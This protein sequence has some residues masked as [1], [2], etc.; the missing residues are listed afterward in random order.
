MAKHSE[1]ELFSQA[2]MTSNFGIWEL[3]I[4]AHT[5][6]WTDGV[7][8]IL[9]YEP[10][11]FEV[12]FEKNLSFVH[13]DDS[14]IFIEQI[15]NTTTTGK[16]FDIRLRFITK[17]GS[18][19]YI[20]AKG[21]LIKDVKGKGLKISGVFQDVSHNVALETAYQKINSDLEALIENTPDVIYSLNSEFKL[22]TFNT[23]FKNTVSELGLGEVEKGMDIF[24]LYSEEKRELY[25]AV[26]LIV[27]EGK[28]YTFEDE[29]IIN[30][31]SVCYD[32]SVN[33]ILST[34]D[35]VIGVSIF[36]KD[37]TA[38][39]Q[40]QKK[41][42][43][44]KINQDAIINSTQDLIWSINPKMRLITANSAFYKMI[45]DNTG[46]IINEGDYIMVAE[47]PKEINEKWLNYYTR[48]LNGETFS[49]NYWVETDGEPFYRLI[50]FSPLF[51]AHQV[52]LGLACYT[53][54][55]TK[56]KLNFLAL[57]RKDAE[58]EKIMNSSLDVI[59]TFNK[60][61]EFVKVNAAS[62]RVW[63]YK[64]EELVGK[65][66]NLF[67]YP[68]DIDST[69]IIFKE[70]QNGLNVINFENRTIK[71]DGTIVPIIWSGTYDDK[72]EI[73][74]CIAKD[75]SALKKK[76]EEL[77]RANDILKNAQKLTKMGNWEY[78]LN[79]NEVFCSDELYSIYEIDKS[80]RANTTPKDFLKFTHP[81]DIATLIEYRDKLI[82]TAGVS[83][84]LHRIITKKNNIKYVRQVVE[85]VYD[86]KTNTK[87]L[88]ATLRD[89][90]SNILAQNEIENS[91]KKYKYLF[92]N[93]P[94]ALF[95][96]EFETLQI[97]DCNYEALELYGYTREEFL[98][99]TIRDIRPAE[100]INLIDTAT[101]NEN[102]YG[103]I[104]KETWRHQKKNRDII[105]AEITG[106]LIDYEGKRCSIALIN[107]ITEKKK[108]DQLLIANEL[109]YRTMIESSMDAILL[110]I[111]TGEILSCNEVACQ[112]FQ[113]TK[114]E[115]IAA[116]RNGL[117]DITDPRLIT[118]LEERNR[119]GKTRGE[120]TFI[121]KNGTKFPGE[122]T[123]VLFMDVN[124]LERAS[125][126]IR[127]ITNQKDAENK[128]FES[129]LRFKYA[130]KATSDAIWDWDLTTNLI[131]YGEGFNAIFGYEVTEI[132]PDISSWSKRIHPDDYN[133]VI[134][135]I[136]LSINNDE[137]Q[138]NWIDEYRYLK[139]DGVYA[140]VQDKGLIVRNKKHKAIRMVGAM[141]DI[142]QK[143]EE[144]LRLKLL[145]SVITN[146]NDSIVITEAEPLDEP[147]PKILYVN[148]AFTRMT[149]YTAEDV[150]GKTPRILQGP[151][152]D[153]KELKK[154]SK[155]LKNREECEI[156]V[157]NYKKNGEEF[158]INLCVTPVANDKGWLTHW[159]AI[160]KDVTE[161]VLAKQ[162]LESSLEERNTILE[163]IDDGFFATDRNSIVTYWNKKA[164][165]LLEEKKEN[166]IGKNLFQMF[167]EA[168]SMVFHDHYQKAIR[169]NKTVHFEEFS[170]RKQKWFEVSAF[171]SDKGLSVYF[172]DITE[173]KKIQQQFEAVISNMP[174]ITYR[175]RVDEHYTMLFMSDGVFDITGYLANDFINNKY[176]TFASIIHDE[177]LIITYNTVETLKVH[178]VF[179]IE[180]RII[181]ADGSIKWVQDK[182]RGV[183]KSDH[184]LLYIDGVV[185]DITDKKN[186]LKELEK[187][188]QEK[189]DVLE[190]ID[191]GFF[192]T[193]RNSIVTYWNKKAELLI[194]EKRENVIGKNL[195]QM[196]ANP[197]SMAFYNHYQKAIKENK[198]VHFEEFSNRRKKW[199][200]VSAF[201]SDKG[202][203]V[204]FKDV[205][206]K[207][208]IE[209]RIKSERNLLR[210]LI[211]NFP[212]TIYVKDVAA[213]KIISNKND[214]NF[215]GF[216]QEED[217]LGKTDLEL[218][219][220]ERGKTGYNHDMEIINTGKA[221]I[222]FEEYVIKNDGNP[223]WLLTTK[224]PL[225]NNENKIIG[226]L[227]IGRD[228]TDIKEAQ[229]RIKHVHIEL[230]K[231]VEQLQISNKELE[232]F[233]YVASHDLQEPLRMITSFLTQI[234]KKYNDVLDDK[235]KQ[236]I[237][238]AVDGAK[239]M[240]QIILDLLE[241]SRI[242]R[243]DEELE[244]VNLM[245]I[246]TEIQ[247]LYKKQI[248]EIPAKINTIKLPKI[249]S[250]KPPIRQVLQN[251]IS[252]ALK[253]HTIGVPTEINI[254]FEDKGNDWQFYVKDNGIGINEEYFPKIFIIFQRLHNK[255]E[256]AGT[257]IGLAIC[258]KIVDSLGGNIW[259]E[260]NADRGTCFYF[261]IPKI[262]V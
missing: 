262:R 123:S 159:I 228:I 90:T 3:D 107:D 239:R 94:S 108:A 114:E 1:K 206:D 116:G 87:W 167:V 71:K 41:L 254:G 166:V 184:S 4:H 187:A 193:D 67:V 154:L 238:F 152:T 140:F 122:I 194:G 179:D 160:E 69:A 117:V 81:D 92:D 112:I 242:G 58:L 73:S 183:Y 241:Y 99:L 9:G 66:Y 165:L 139:A 96:F 186:N 223:L 53:K 17:D 115:V 196:F 131:Y 31:K 125:T 25:S 68:D 164:E 100:D 109:K 157:I 8:R 120:L 50:S 250:Y 232:Q 85:L 149:G 34:N 162:K 89:S 156:T 175:C 221:L 236:Y 59:C 129:N 14:A 128:I 138:D 36:S 188:Y 43:R 243:H 60:E 133:R 5:L 199:F 169:E 52:V 80:E 216:E 135:S 136:H 121:R 229:E 16:D 10:Q 72:E 234:E 40:K 177:D 46:K 145:E 181:C 47:Y 240:R 171:P 142:T 198:S 79:T 141:Q 27:K 155:A 147:G 45:K 15:Q 244:E 86:E 103:E 110:T 111:K 37:V 74:Y 172:K 126:I 19:K 249:L 170:T 84:L 24:K 192:A 38:K 32:V 75:A 246:I 21:K 230:E 95:I 218:F 82:A 63:G 144:S 143:K 13:P 132:E 212:D 231:S 220:D 174:G 42:E 256:Y 189:S 260:A 163:S 124:G 98:K 208:T 49:I 211:D 83:S 222:N 252:N 26:F 101:E 203:S 195:H 259:V 197:N 210:T 173:R 158:Y 201:P 76:D 91:R 97:V 151:K 105:Y 39:K 225:K 93:N 205:T 146:T 214:C 6:Y 180:Y 77:Q 255:E 168:N 113:M 61:G 148:A 257:G 161:S 215:I 54:D 247:S 233:A 127:D 258:K 102:T 11:E 7:F 18:I 137:L 235:G 104:H 153:K 253:Y 23:A 226:L 55:I 33:P 178:D 48:G 118:L 219:G 22:L 28:N 200:E 106:H 56:E 176:R 150:I 130:T 20:N 88:Y 30:G 261:T 57:E 182:G 119:T 202:L 65:Q 248:D 190:S 134:E 209:E 2:E 217:V 237:Y 44:I 251:L 70:V 78:N 224:V 62:E 64:P 12:T 227:G 29:L 51:S 245:E 191:D 204:Y 213:K 35:E 185:M 207:K